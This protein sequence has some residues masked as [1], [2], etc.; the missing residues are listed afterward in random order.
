[1][2][3]EVMFRDK[4]V[5]PP[6]PDG[7]RIVYDAYC[8]T[9]TGYHFVVEMQRKQ[10]SLFG[11]RMVF[12]ISSCIFRQGESGG[13]YKFEPVYLIVITDFDMKPFEK[14]L[15]NEVILMERNTHVAFTEDVKIILPVAKAC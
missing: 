10:S 8:T 14:R 13:T 12:Y 5:L 1:M 4:E 11:K 7:K 15:V 6:G 9:T 3:S 2:I